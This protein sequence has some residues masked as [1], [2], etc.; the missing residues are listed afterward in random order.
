[1]QGGLETS[2]EMPLPSCVI[3]QVNVRPHWP[4][5]CHTPHLSVCVGQRD[6]KRGRAPSNCPQ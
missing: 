1:M 3:S 6:R 2:C 4:G 5:L